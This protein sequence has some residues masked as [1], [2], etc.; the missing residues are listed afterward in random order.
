MVAVM[1]ACPFHAR[2]LPA[3]TFYQRARSVFLSSL[4]H[5]AALLGEEVESTMAE[6]G[7]GGL[8]GGQASAAGGTVGARYAQKSAKGLQIKG[9]VIAEWV[10]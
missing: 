1:L 2:S 3:L 6:S 5:R 9:K 8:Y 4:Y 7:F 10:E